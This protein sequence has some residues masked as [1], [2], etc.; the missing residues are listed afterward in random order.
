MYWTEV[1]LWHAEASRIAQAQGKV[2][3][4]NA[5]ISAGY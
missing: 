1:L 4:V 2:T 3:H 5:D